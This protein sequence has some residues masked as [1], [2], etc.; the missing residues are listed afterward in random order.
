VLIRIAQQPGE[1]AEQQAAKNK[2]HDALGDSVEY[3]REEVVGTR[4][5]RASTP[6]S[7]EC[8]PP[9]RRSVYLW[10]RFEWQLRSAP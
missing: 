1:E 5:G 6:A 3:R 8:S 7:S 2:V 4:V 10:F 9:S